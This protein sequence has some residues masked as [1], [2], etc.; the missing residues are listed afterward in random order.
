MGIDSDIRYYKNKISKIQKALPNV[1]AAINNYNKAIDELKKIKGVARCNE[2]RTKV[3]TKI[4]E[5]ESL[6]NTMNKEIK[7][8]NSKIKSLQ[9]QK[10]AQEST[11]V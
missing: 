10:E 5:L 7:T 1:K 6:I 11:S 9:R 4:T 2:L 8:Y 3:Q